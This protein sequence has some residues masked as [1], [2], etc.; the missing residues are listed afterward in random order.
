MNRDNTLRRWLPRLVVGIGGTLALSGQTASAQMREPAATLMPARPSL[1][2]SVIR[3]ATPDTIPPSF[4]GSYVPSVP[5]P[6]Y[7]GNRGDGSKSNWVGA[8]WAGLKETVIGKP[9][10][11]GAK[12]AE[13]DRRSPTAPTSPLIGTGSPSPVS[14]QQPLQSVYASPPAYRWYGW[15]GTTPGANPHSPS[16]V[17][18]QGSANWYSQT[19]ATPGAFPDTRTKHSLETAP[20]EP[21]VYTGKTV[22]ETPFIVG[23]P[24]KPAE[25]K[26]APRYISGPPNPEPKV[27]ARTAIVP[28]AG[29]EMPSSPSLPSGTPVA[30]ASSTEGSSL[31]AE[32][33]AQ[34]TG[35]LNWQTAS[36]RGIPLPKEPAPIAPSPQPVSKEPAWAPVPATPSKL[37][38]PTVSV[39]R[40][41]LDSREPQSLE[42]LIRNASVGRVARSDVRAITAK[43]LVVTFVVASENAAREAAALVAKL[44]ELKPYEVTFEAQIVGR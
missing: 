39:I 22:N 4:T 7:S 13:P 30:I 44:P 8:K 41:Q 27:V 3:G 19:G 18:P 26:P 16:G 25:P 12:T 33:V 40:G 9:N 20:I 11:S 43:R 31:P 42:I 10:P 36:S 35:E 23:A 1:A 6:N 15:G 14:V 17:Y 2:P 28:P 34:P 24:T 21:P 38:A 32:T 5:A 29:F 37:P